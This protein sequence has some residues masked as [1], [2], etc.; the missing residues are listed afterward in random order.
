MVIIDKQIQAS[1]NRK[2]NNNGYTKRWRFSQ[3]PKG[4]PGQWPQGWTWRTLR[5]EAD[6]RGIKRETLLDGIISGQV[7]GEPAKKYQAENVR[8]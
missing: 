5:R 7:T 4:R 1:L 8:Q 3:R 2:E 6:A